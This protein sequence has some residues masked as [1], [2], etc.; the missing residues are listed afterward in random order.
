MKCPNCQGT[1]DGCMYCEESGEICDVCGEATE[2]GQN[3]CEECQT[4]TE[5]D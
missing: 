4:E 5:Q 1:G 2:S 3:V